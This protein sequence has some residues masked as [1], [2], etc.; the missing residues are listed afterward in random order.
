MKPY[1]SSLFNEVLVSSQ[2]VRVIVYYRRDD[3]C[4][5]HSRSDMYAVEVIFPFICVCG[6]PTLVD[7]ISLIRELNQSGVKRSVPVDC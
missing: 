6:V 1:Q 3:R 2:W 4:S 7:N 5:C